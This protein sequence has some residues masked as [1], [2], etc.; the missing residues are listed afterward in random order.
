MADIPT[1]KYALEAELDAL[2]K[3]KTEGT[4]TMISPSN[5]RWDV[6]AQNADILA[7]SGFRIETPEEAARIRKEQEFGTG[8]LNPVITAAESLASTVS[9]GASDIVL[10]ESGIDPNI[11]FRRE[12]N[13]RANIA[14]TALGFAVPVLGEAGIAR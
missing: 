5:E 13:P 14:G 12:V 8:I 1:D 9:L 3:K 7:Q 11:Q 6:P 10:K 4:V 2:L